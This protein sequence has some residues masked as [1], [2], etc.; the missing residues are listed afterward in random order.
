MQRSTFML[1]GAAALAFGATA[2][3]DA[4]D[5]ADVSVMYAGSLVTVME[6]SVVPALRDRGLNVLGE[7]KGS[8]AIANLITSGL[9]HPDVFVSADVAVIA[10]LLGTGQGAIAS[11]YAPFA[12]TRLVIGYSAASRF[13]SDF[14]ACARGEK[15]LTSVLLEPGLKLGRTDP[16]LDPKGYRSIIAAKL[17]EADGGAPG[18]ADKLLGDPKNASEVFPEE[19]LLVRLESGELDA[20]FLYATESVARNVPAVELP[21]TANLGDPALAAH[22]ATQ[23]VTIDGITRT[24]SPAVYAL[25]IL[26]QPPHPEAAE[27]FV[28]YLFS[29]AGG[30]LLTASGVTVLH[31]DIVGDKTAV[32]AGVLR[33][34]P[35]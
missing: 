19:T 15:K 7:P 29:E 3:A 26:N 20:A 27:R 24:G 5:A 21:K 34:L 18:F 14:A 4:A 17:L 23:S 16:A 8:V 28:S 30:T 10:K 1:S 22:Y 2:R 6:R 9:R 35:A 13:A 33:A 31:P 11:W 32:P 25:T 12:T